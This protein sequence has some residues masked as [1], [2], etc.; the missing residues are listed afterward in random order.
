M[1]KESV[2]SLFD[3]GD[4]SGTKETEVNHHF[5]P[6]HQ[7]SCIRTLIRSWAIGSGSGLLTML[8]F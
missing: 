8:Q 3:D 2:E 6:F 5:Q 1:N 4:K 7:S